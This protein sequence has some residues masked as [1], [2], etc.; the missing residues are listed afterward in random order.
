MTSTEE[1]LMSAAFALLGGLVFLLGL[2]KWRTCRIIRDTP[3][4][5]IRSMAMGIV[6]IHGNVE[7][8]QLI[9]SPFSKTDC[10]YYKWEIKEY[11]KSG[12][13]SGKRSTYQWVGVGSGENSVPFF[14]KDDTG[15]ALVNPEKAEFVVSYK[16]VYYQKGQGLLASLKSIPKIVESIKN[17]DPT[18]PTNLVVDGEPLV[19]LASGGS[20]GSVKVGDRKY[21]EHYVVP[22]DTLFVLGKAANDSSAPDNVVIRRG[23]N[24][25][26]FIISDTP[27][28]TVLKN[29]TTKV[30]ASIIIGGI[31]LAV[32]IIMF[33]MNTG[34]IPKG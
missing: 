2:F 16:K 13:S 11:R 19:P 32:G 1:H 8:D 4:S 23:K 15:R 29:L 25:K 31:F 18:N 3:R 6:E 9:K 24:E 10:V 28:K 20:I 34:V 17:F 33:L 21:Y 12:S 5:K 30:W 7:A 27:E 26:T 14:A 22:G